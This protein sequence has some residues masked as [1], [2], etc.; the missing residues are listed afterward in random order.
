MVLLHSC[1][2]LT[3]YE[4]EGYLE[5]AF[6]GSGIELIQHPLACLIIPADAGQI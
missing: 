2:E 1:P 6:L 4:D 5:F 3:Q